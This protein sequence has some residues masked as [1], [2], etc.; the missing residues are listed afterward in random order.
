MA[1]EA[2]REDERWMA[3]ALALGA[4]GLGTVWPNP[5]VG[6]VLTRDGAV[7]GRGWTRPGGRPHAET[8]ALRRAGAKAKGATAYVS[9]E[10]CD[11]HGGTPPCSRALIDAGIARCVFA[12]EDPDPRVSG[13]GGARLRAAGVGVVEGVRAEEAAEINRG[14]ILHR[15]AGRPLVTW[16]VASALDGRIATGGGD[17]KWITG[18]AARAHAHLLRA[19]HDAVLIG[20]RT[21]IV[22]RS[23]L[24]CRLP[25]MEAYSP[26]RVVVDSRLQLPLTDP[27]I[28]EAGATPAWIVCRADT[29]GARARAYEECGATVIPVEADAAG[30]SMAAAFAALAE[31]GITRVL[32]EGGGRIAASL[33]RAG[34]VDRIEWFRAAMLIGGDGIPAAA[35]LGLGAVADAPRFRRTG[36]RRFGDDILESYSAVA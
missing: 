17:S 12:L 2:S 36:L 29:D 4:R 22:D 3:V 9:L 28:A 33:L 32:V 5:A 16:K 26:V 25:G 31:R 19:R 11:H 8:E 27:P 20:A 7:V 30:V 21:A 14:F 24:T 6:C 1:P 15:S 35:A 18:D 23:R 34:L 13:R 10:P